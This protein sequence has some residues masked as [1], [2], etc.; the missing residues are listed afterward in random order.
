MTFLRGNEFYPIEMATLVQGYW[1]PFANLCQGLLGGMALAHLVFIRTNY[2][3]LGSFIVYYANFC[4]IF[5][6]LFYFLCVIC[7]ISVFDR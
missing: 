1:R 5:V 6:C 7:L 4:D 2:D 3:E